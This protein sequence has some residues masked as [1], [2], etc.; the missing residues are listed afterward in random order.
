MNYTLQSELASVSPIETPIIS[1]NT[2]DKKVQR[3]RQR[4][5]RTFLKKEREIGYMN[6]FEHITDSTQK[7]LISNN[8]IQAQQMRIL[9]E[10]GKEYLKTVLPV[11]YKSEA[12]I[13]HTKETMLP[14][15]RSEGT[16]ENS[17]PFIPK[18]YKNA[19]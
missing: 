15:L 3:K 4:Q 7:S 8:N 6:S 12:T 5:E 19:A 18:E 9:K 17:V 14:V 11:P 16:A 2:H 10:K 13:L 1:E